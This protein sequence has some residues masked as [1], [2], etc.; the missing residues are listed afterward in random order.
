M[1]AIVALRYKDGIIL[2]ADRQATRGYS[3]KKTENKIRYYEQSNTALTS[4]GYVKYMNPFMYNSTDIIPAS[5]DKKIIDDE[6]A[7]YTVLPAIV[8]R[9]EEKNF[10]KEKPYTFDDTRFIFCTSEDIYEFDDY[11]SMWKV[12][13]ET[14]FYC[15]GSGEEYSTGYLDNHDL[16][17]LSKEKAIELVNGALNAAK[18]HDNYCSYD[19][20]IVVIENVKKASD[21]LKWH[22]AEYDLPDKCGD[23]VVKYEYEDRFNTL[24]VLNFDPEQNSF[25]KIVSDKIEIVD[26]IHIEY[27]F[28]L[29]RY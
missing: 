16:T 12:P 17:D 4:T 7:Y 9:L 15:V 10:W 20:Q 8:K 13:R 26:A 1:T 3:K 18:N 5:Y 11:N 21:N 2:G 27:W 6:Y 28:P 23:Y 19:N 25:Y 29:P 24:E 22:Y 14:P